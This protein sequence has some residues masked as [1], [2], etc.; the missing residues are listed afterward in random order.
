ME[1]RGYDDFTIGRL[2]GRT[3]SY[4]NIINYSNEEDVG[5]MVLREDEDDD[6]DD[7]L[8]W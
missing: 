8:P 6:D 7:V 5:V 4:I 1:V 2:I 3:R